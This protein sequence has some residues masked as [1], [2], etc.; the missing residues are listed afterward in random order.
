MLND[1]HNLPE[2]LEKYKTQSKTWVSV[3]NVFY[4]IKKVITG[5]IIVLIVFS[6]IFGENLFAELGISTLMLLIAVVITSFY[7]SKKEVYYDVELRFFDDF[8]VL[9]RNKIPYT[10][11]VA[12]REYLTYR[13]ISKARYDYK[14]RRLD[15]YGT[16]EGLLYNYKKNGLLPA[17]PSKRINVSEAYDSIYTV[18]DEDINNII[19]LFKKY[20]NCKIEYAHEEYK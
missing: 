4:Y 17:E 18:K 11:K 6:F 14:I 1:L 3:K 5:L 7:K 20:T 10:P 12:R 2:P 19:N 13:N 16:L 15:I 9:Y 8:V